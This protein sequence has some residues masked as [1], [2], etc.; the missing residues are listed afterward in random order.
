[1]SAVKRICAFYSHGPHYAQV[2]K[3]LRKTYPDANI[4]AMTPPGYPREPLT[5]LANRHAESAQAT[6]SLRDIAALRLLL[7][8]I[9]D[10]RYDLFVVMFDSPKLHLFA[11]LTRVRRRY[12][13]TADGRYYPLRLS[14][15]R[16]LSTTLYRNLRGRITYA[17][18]RYVVYHRPVQKGGE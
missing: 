5:P 2:L 17:Y 4:T 6:Y 10:G 1:M 16:L 3:H 15:I 9:R 7:R 12:C 14:L 18:I 11:R 8:Q 13:Y